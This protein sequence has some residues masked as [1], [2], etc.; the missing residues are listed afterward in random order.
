MTSFTL[1]VVYTN[2]FQREL[3][4]AKKRGLKIRKLEKVIELLASGEKLPVKLRD[5]KLTNYSEYAGVRE[6]HIEPDWLLIYSIDRGALTLY[7]L[8]TGT[9][10]DVFGK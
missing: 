5:H 7:L 3:K 9:H 4:L 2:K 10:S 8:R 6:C 1:K